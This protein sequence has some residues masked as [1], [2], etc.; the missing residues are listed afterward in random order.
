MIHLSEIH[1]E[2]KQH[3]GAPKIH[4]SLQKEGYRLSLK[5][6][7]H[8][9]KKA[10]IRSIVSKKYCPYPS[11]QKVE[12]RENLLEQDFTTNSNLRIFKFSQNIKH[13]FPLAKRSLI[14]KIM[15]NLLVNYHIVLYYSTRKLFFISFFFRKKGGLIMKAVLKNSGGLTKRVKVGF[16]WTT[17]F[18]GFFPALFRGDLT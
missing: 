4:H 9:M 13:H 17:F 16:S 6:V 10:G 11:K 3:Y 15:K 5:R 12:E 1:T 8:L 2:S 18:F 7:Q 14:S